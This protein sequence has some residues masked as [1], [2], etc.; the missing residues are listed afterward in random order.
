LDDFDDAVTN[1]AIRE[2]NA[3]DTE[4]ERQFYTLPWETHPGIPLSEIFAGIEREAVDAAT[5]RGDFKPLLNLLSSNNPMNSQSHI[6]LAR[7]LKLDTYDLIGERAAGKRKK[8][9]APQQSAEMRRAQTPT[10]DA[11][12]DAKRI[13][14]ILRDAYPTKADYVLQGQSFHAAA[15]L[16]I[17]DFRKIEKYKDITEE[18]LGQLIAG[19]AEAG[20]NHHRNPTRHPKE[21]AKKKARSK[22]KLSPK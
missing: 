17:A 3:A 21:K 20:P 5:E 16:W 1:W 6:P 13:E 14:L 2:L 12:A 8:N 19:Y 9:G 4:A 7:S 11:A 22:T 15:R 10:S 18:R